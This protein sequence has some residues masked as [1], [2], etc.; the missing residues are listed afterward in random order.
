MP[1]Q[2]PLTLHQSATPTSPN[3]S[4]YEP[5]ACF[6]LQGAKRVTMGDRIIDYRP[7]Q[8]LIASVSLPVIGEVIE[9]DRGEPY[10]MVALAL[11]P[12]SI[13][14]LLL[15]LSAQE[16]SPAPI[17]LSVSTLTPH[18]ADALFRLIRLLDE[19]DDL[20]VMAPML[21]RE[22]LYRML[23]GP[24]GG[25]LRQI[26]RSDSHLSRLRRA[27]DWIRGHY[28][29]PLTIDHL[30]DLANMSR[31]SFHRHFKAVTAMSPLTYQKQIR[32]QEA[33]R[34]L[35][36]TA[37]G[38]AHIAYAVGYESPSQFSREYTRLFGL[39]PGRDG[40]RL[41]DHMAAIVT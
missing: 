24:Q 20:A 12:A 36:T 15:D 4:V 26:A 39:P 6:I 23:Q 25:I 11:D 38:A 18:L 13:G 5:M 29:E 31:S 40:V 9:A 27:I 33:R 32:L 41:R 14:A 22:M 3:H 10:R 17:G 35:V 37:E 2:L 8:F 7:G 19:P 21:E 16:E 34:Q 1:G 28:A 30:A